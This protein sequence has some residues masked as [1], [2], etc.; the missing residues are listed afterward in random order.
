MIYQNKVIEYSNFWPKN[1]NQ[2]GKN[3]DIS[4]FKSKQI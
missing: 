4:N 1:T 2:E 3:A